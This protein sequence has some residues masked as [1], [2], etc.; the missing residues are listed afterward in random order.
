MPHKTLTEVRAQYIKETD[1]IAKKRRFGLFT[2]PPSLAIGD[3][4]YTK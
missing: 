4:S 1:N 3:N 2:N